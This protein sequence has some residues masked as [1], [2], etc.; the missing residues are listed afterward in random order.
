M[1]FLKWYYVNNNEK[2][3]LLRGELGK[4]WLSV[5]L[6]FCGWVNGKLMQAAENTISTNGLK[7]CWKWKVSRQK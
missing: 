6:G 3:Y 7:S 5:F 4:I 2:I 1:A